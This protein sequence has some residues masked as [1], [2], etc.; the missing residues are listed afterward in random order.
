[1]PSPL[2][3]QHAAFAREY[4]VDYNAKNAAIRAGYSERTAKNQGYRLLQREDIQREISRL[5]RLAEERAE[6]KVDDVVA[7]FTRIGFTGMSRFVKIDEDGEPRIDLGDCT[8]EDLDLLTEITT[9]TY[10]EGNGEEKKPV[11]RVKIKLMDRHKAL[12]RLYAHLGGGKG[13]DDPVDRLSRALKEI[14]ERG[15]AAPIATANK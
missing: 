14:C 10:L 1:M 8:A 13:G 15:S 6:K 5:E 9:E 3:P 4:I 11:R 12:E 7:E 2:N